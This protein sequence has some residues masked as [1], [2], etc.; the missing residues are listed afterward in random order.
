MHINSCLPTCHKQLRSDE[1]R[2]TG[3]L[4]LCMTSFIMSENFIDIIKYNIWVLIWFNEI[5]E[6][7][8]YSRIKCS[9][10]L[11]SQ[12]SVCEFSLLHVEM[13]RICLYVHN[14]Y[15][16]GRCTTF[17]NFKFSDTTFGRSFHWFKVVGERRVDKSIYSECDII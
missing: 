16:P 8:N 2:V 14:T 9:K 4:Y 12:N 11:T 7:A 17:I 5:L 10:T 6:G 1:V 13:V 15:L 3:L